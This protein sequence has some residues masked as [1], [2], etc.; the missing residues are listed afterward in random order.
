MSLNYCRRGGRREGGS[1]WSRM[2]FGCR[3]HLFW[4]LC[5]FLWTNSGKVSV[6]SSF[7]AH[8]V[9]LSSAADAVLLFFIWVELWEEVVTL[10]SSLVFSKTASFFGVIHLHCFF[11]TILFLLFSQYINLLG[12]LFKFQGFH[13]PIFLNAHIKKKTMHM[14]TAWWKPSDCRLSAEGPLLFSQ[15]WLNLLCNLA[16]TE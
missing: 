14:K 11:L 3:F 12:H 15:L 16:A 8:F 9:L 10:H 2:P 6:S 5:L 7:H 1:S 4:H 13:Q